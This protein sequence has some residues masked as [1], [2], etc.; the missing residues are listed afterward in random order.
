MVSI[1]TTPERSLRR[2]SWLL[3]VLGAVLVGAI[4]VGAYFNWYLWHPMSGVVVTIVSVGLLLVGGLALLVRSSRLRPIGLVLVV[5]AVGTVAGQQLGPDRPE[6][7]RHESGSLRLVLTAP[8]ALDA[9]G[10]ASCGS[11]ADA[12]QVVVDPDEFGVARAS[13]EAD[14]HYAYVTVGDMYDFGDR[15][16]R[17]D[18]LSVV[19]SV[20]SAMI[21]ADADP[22][23]RPGETRHSSD[24]VSNLVLAPGHSIDGGSITFSNLA[25]GDP[26]DPARRS[27]LVGTVSWTCGPLSTGPG[28]GPGESP[29]PEDDLPDSPLPG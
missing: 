20:I 8:S 29:P 11:A 28:P 26:A 1:P 13:E 22:N 4:G 9:S 24:A 15:T 14:F 3:P 25:L 6:V 16:A 7:R 10:K 27:D 2:P 17:S 18:H 5:A 21:P 23:V 12:S 19:I